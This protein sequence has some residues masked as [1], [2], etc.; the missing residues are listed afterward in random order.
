M[1]GK[2]SCVPRAGCKAGIDLLAPG[3]ARG[4]DV[5]AAILCPLGATPQHGVRRR[6]PQARRI[7]VNRLLTRRLL[8]SECRSEGQPRDWRTARVTAVRGVLAGQDDK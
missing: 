7:I 2:R 8:W 5:T 3:H 1:S 4:G 6:R